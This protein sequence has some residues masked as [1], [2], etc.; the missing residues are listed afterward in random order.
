MFVIVVSI[1]VGL[2]RADI[3]FKTEMEILKIFEVL[4]LHCP[5][6]LLEEASLAQ[7]RDDSQIAN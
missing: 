5:G 2:G 1:V 7:V 3:S 6:S 4:L